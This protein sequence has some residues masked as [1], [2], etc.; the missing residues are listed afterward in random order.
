M[1][2]SRDREVAWSAS[3]RQSSNVESCVWSAVSYHSP[4]HPQEVLLAQ[5]SL[6]VLYGLKPHS[7]NFILL[8]FFSIGVAVTLILAKVAIFTVSMCFTIQLL[9]VVGLFIY[10]SPHRAVPVTCCCGLAT[11]ICDRTSYSSLK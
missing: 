1:G 8:V 10:S 5:F 2:S 9:F 3:D 6:Y 11:H 7:L 4:P